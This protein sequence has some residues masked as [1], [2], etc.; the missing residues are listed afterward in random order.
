VIV[1]KK[2]FQSVLPSEC[3]CAKVVLGQMTDVPVGSQKFN[4]MKDQFCP[5]CSCKY[6]EFGCPE[7]F[8][9]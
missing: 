2:Q 1:K 3:E 5:R 9:F 4:Q 8:I 6:G 7:K